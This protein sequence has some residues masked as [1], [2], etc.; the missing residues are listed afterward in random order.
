M[1][2]KVLF[3]LLVFACS[4]LPAVS[5]AQIRE[6]SF[7]IGP[8]VGLHVF[9]HEKNDNDDHYGR[10]GI[11][12]LRLG[13]NFTPKIGAELSGEN[14][15]GRG[16]QYHADVLYHFTPDRA[17]VPFAVAGLGYAHI[18]PWDGDSYGSVLGNFGLGFKYFLHKNIA[19]RVDVRDVITNR[20][21][22]EFTTGIQF[23]FGGKTPPPPPAPTPPPPPPAPKPEPTPPPPPPPAKKVEPAPAPEPVKIVLEDVHFDFDKATLTKEAKAILDR[24]IET[25]KANPGVK[26]QIEGHTCAHGKDDYNM[27][28]GER[29]ANAVKE[30]LANAGIA[31]SRMSTISYGETRLAMPETPTPQNKNSKEAKANRRVHF[32]V[33]VK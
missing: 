25:L 3:L 29:R 1:N 5:S 19:W 6:G 11:L 12:G 27:A 18:R 4:L 21:N 24:N 33:I 28:L 9:D 17:F 26:V 8:F 20:Q 23:A 30:Y 31:G 22:V 13:Y 32:E 10:R 2:K 15:D 7:E 16:Q 14:I